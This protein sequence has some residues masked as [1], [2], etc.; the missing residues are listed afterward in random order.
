MNFFKP[1]FWD[2]KQASLFS[3]L[4]YPISLIYTALGFLNKLFTKEQTFSI[5]VICIGNIYVGG[6]GK[7]P[8]C[9]ELFEILKKLNKNPAFIKKK[10]NSFQDESILLKKIGPLYENKK[11][12]DAINDAIKNNANVAI[13]DDG[14]QDRSI[15]KDLSIICFNEKQWIGNGMKLPSGPLRET[16]ASLKRS[17]IVIINGKK[18]SDIENK[19]LKIKDTIKIFYVKNKTKN[20]E[21][22]K[23]KKIIAFAGIGNPINF[24]NFLKESNLNIIENISFPDHYIFKK[25]DLENLFKMAEKN[26]ATLLTTE[27]DYCRINI[28]NKEEISFLKLKVEIENHDKFLEE[29]KKII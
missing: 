13:L 28:I 26:N 11:R 14:F 6:T 8:F 1:K 24:F 29:I 18:N 15:K 22:F 23:E 7:T 3:L 27:K 10:Y 17:K 21:K 2:K 9:C 4:L 12:V 16:L 25:K 20:I 19:I 5:P